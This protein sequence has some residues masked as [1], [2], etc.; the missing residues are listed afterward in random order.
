MFGKGCDRGG[1]GRID[2]TFLREYWIDNYGRFCGYVD[3]GPP[4][5]EPFIVGNWFRWGHTARVFFNGFES[6]LLDVAFKELGEE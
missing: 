6:E 1:G 3:E 4:A 5:K 2:N